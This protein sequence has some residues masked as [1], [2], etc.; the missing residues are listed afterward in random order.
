M[1][2]HGSGYLLGW[3][4]LGGS[5]AKMSLGNMDEAGAG[6]EFVAAG[7]LLLEIC[8]YLVECLLGF[9]ACLVVLGRGRRCLESSMLKMSVY[10]GN[11]LGCVCQSGVYLCCQC[12]S[13]SC[14]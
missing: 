4:P 10:E 12:R 11:C 7:V 9:V 14:L 2:D 8:C 1:R 3:L 5:D 13:G 6:G